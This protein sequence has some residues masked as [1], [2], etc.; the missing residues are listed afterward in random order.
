MFGLICVVVIVG[1]IRDTI[2]PGRT[3]VVLLPVLTGI[4]LGV[5]GIRRNGKDS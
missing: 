1:L 4:V 5:N 3:V 2:D